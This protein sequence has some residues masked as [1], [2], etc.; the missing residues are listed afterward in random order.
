[1]LLSRNSVHATDA[2]PSAALCLATHRLLACLLS[3]S[4]P[5]SHTASLALQTFPELM[6]V[7]LAVTLASQAAGNA[8]NWGPDRAKV[9][10]CAAALCSAPPAMMPWVLCHAAAMEG[11]HHDDDGHHAFPPRLQCAISPTVRPS[12]FPPRDSNALFLPCPP[13]HLQADRGTRSIFS[14][15][16][17]TPLVDAA[18]AAGEK[19]ATSARGAL[20]FRDVTFRYPTRPDGPP[21]LNKLNLVVRPGQKVALVGALI[22]VADDD[23]ADADDGAACWDCRCSVV[24]ASRSRLSPSSSHRCPHHCLRPASLGPAGPSGCGKS[25]IISLLERFYVPGSGAILLDGAPLESYNVAWLRSQLGLIQ[26]EPTLF[27]DR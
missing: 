5:C 25:T 21:A 17:R 1:M 10:T 18:S 16:D 6:R 26:Q 8:L 2:A 14:L 27:A 23:H 22:H 19:P 24:V 15:V 13:L 7:F 20:E 9:S 11:L 3:H 12:C 4:L